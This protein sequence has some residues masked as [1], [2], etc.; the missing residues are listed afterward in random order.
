MLAFRRPSRPRSIQFWLTCLVIACILPAAI[1]ATVLMLR[2]YEQDRANLEVARIGVARALMQAVD[3]EMAGAASVLQVLA[4]SPLLAAGD[5]AA[6][7]TLA[8]HALGTT[9]GNNILLSLPSGPEV[10]NTLK[11]YGTPLP[12]HGDPETQRRA[13]ET[14]GV[15]ISGVFNGPVA[16]QPVIVVELPVFIDG[17][18]KYTLAMAFFSKRLSQILLRQKMPPDWV[19]ALYD[20]HGLV[21]ARTKAADRFVGKPGASEM[22]RYVAEVPEGALTTHTLEGDAIQATFSRSA[23][24]GWAVIIGV[25]ANSATAALRHSLWLNAMGAL[26]ALLLAGALA[27]CISQR[28]ARSLIALGEPALALGS[29]GTVVLSTSGIIEID[30]LRTMLL[31]ASDLIEQRAQE[32]DAAKHA[33]RRMVISTEA[34]EHANRAK[35]QF[36]ASMSHELRTPLHGILGYADLIR[37]DGGLAPVQVHRLDLML[38]AGQ[39]LLGMINAVLD[40]SQI[41]ANQLEVRPERVVLSDL[42]RACLDV[43]RPSA[44]KKGLA[45]MPPPE[46][47]LC[48][49]VDPT[50]LRQVIVNLLG[51]AVKFTP[52]GTVELRLSQATSP[53]TMRLEV[54]DTGAGI[55][56]RHHAKLFQS[57]ERLD[58]SAMRSVEGAGLGLALSAR[59]IALMGGSLGYNDNPGGGSIF[60]LELPFGDAQ[61][62]SQPVPTAIEVVDQQ[63]LM[64]ALHIL[65]VDDVEMNRDIA[66]CFLEWAG[67]RV[68]CAESG[69]QAVAAAAEMD[70]DVILMDVRMPGMD[71]LE[72]TRRIRSLDSR[73][74]RVPIVALTAQAFTEQVAECRVAGMDFHLGKP[75]DRPGLLAAVARAGE[76]ALASSAWGS[77]LPIPA[78]STGT[79]MVPVIGS[80]LRVLDPETFELIAACLASDVVASHLQTIAKRSKDLVRDLRRPEALLHARDQLTEAAHTLAGS[81]GMFGFERLSIIGRKLE[82]AIQM[83]APEVPE[84]SHGFYAAV[85]ATLEEIR[86]RMGLYT[87]NRLADVAR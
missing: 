47:T 34:A 66:C 29:G 12:K 36:L 37:L 62:L 43:V 15:V 58:G 76:Q 3:G 84:L 69:E 40:L 41:E 27:R 24:S 54:V 44:E 35:S 86:H 53:T 30:A 23:Y 57:F 71:G 38:S 70:F 46:T 49:F 77:P 10:M 6:F 85:E 60:W 80:E 11:P 1:G 7:Q 68:S 28:I 2:S 16:V 13:I 25:P 79:R 21:A 22:V 4:E 64:R 32:R 75:F 33:E 17:Q 78:A 59:L 52:V 5:L 50:R 67:H 56:P 18:V 82:Q 51:N 87:E 72:A 73:R 19:A 31:K 8:D 74:G 42:L 14:G 65:V 39:H 45:L 48:L 81:A 9:F 20:Q 63:G 61:A 55:P 26:T 83:A